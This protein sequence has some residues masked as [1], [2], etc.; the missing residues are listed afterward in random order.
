MTS[1]SL[2]SC[3]SA[4]GSEGTWEHYI[5]REAYRAHFPGNNLQKRRNQVDKTSTLLNGG[6]EKQAGSY[7][8][9]YQP[10]AF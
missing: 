10:E 7:P 5:L 9:P 2:V 8:L 1:Y 6:L 4:N 3:Q